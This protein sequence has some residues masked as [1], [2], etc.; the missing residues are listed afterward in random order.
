MEIIRRE[1]VKTITFYDMFG[2]PLTPLEVWKNLGVKA[3][4]AEVFKALEALERENKIIKK[5]GY[6]FLPKNDGQ[7]NDLSAQRKAR[8]L[9][10]FKKLQKAKRLVRL[11]SFFPFVRFAGVCNSLG[12]FNAREASDIDFFIIVKSGRIWTARFLTTILLKIFKLRPGAQKTADKF[13]LSF[14]VADSALDISQVAL[15]AGDPYFYHWLSWISPMYDDGVWKQFITS[16]V[17]IK[18]HLPQFM[19]Q[20]GLK[21]SGRSPLKKIK[22]KLFFLPESFFRK[23]QLAAMPA[24]LKAAASRPD[25]SV[26][27]SDAMLKFHLLDRR[28]EYRGNYELRIKNYE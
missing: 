14:Y 25:H 7:I 8:F 17:W 19:A 24:D 22:E 27:I 20:D 12:Y 3:A 1:V 26:V 28:E 9:I 18:N 4:L 11:F 16:N 6:F 2:F 21:F 10:S 15:P 23:I 13:C 5:D